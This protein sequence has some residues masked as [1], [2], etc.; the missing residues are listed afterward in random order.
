MILQCVRNAHSHCP[1]TNAMCRGKT[2]IASES[3]LFD[4]HLPS[5]SLSCVACLKK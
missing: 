2:Y 3:V 5:L 1:H 4:F